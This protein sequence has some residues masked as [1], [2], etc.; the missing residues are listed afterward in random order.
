MG[1]KLSLKPGE[2]IAV[3]GAVIVNGDRRAEFIVE[4]KAS[5]LRE[6]DIMRAEEATTP[7][8]RVY[9]PVMMMALDPSEKARLFAEFERRLT[10]IAGVLLDPAA[11]SLCLKISAA[12]ANGAYYKALGHCRAL[13]DY[14]SERLNN[15]A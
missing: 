9:L 11:L 2:K 8:R 1:L 7:A 12:V 15:V 4:N 10:E 5:I 3:N 13:I 6:R 14:E